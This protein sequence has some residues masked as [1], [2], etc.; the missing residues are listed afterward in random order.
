MGW[1]VLASLAALLGALAAVPL[2]I[3]WD[4]WRQPKWSLKVCPACSGRCWT[5]EL[6]YPIWRGPEYERCWFCHGAGMAIYGNPDK[7]PDKVHRRLDRL[8]AEFQLERRGT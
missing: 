8:R 6:V 3:W 7:A 2:S 1:L 5:L 4:Y